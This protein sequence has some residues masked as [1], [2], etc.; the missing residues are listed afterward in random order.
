MTY[1]PYYQH[2]QQPPKQDCD[3]DNYNYNLIDVVNNSPAKFQPINKEIPTTEDMLK[4]GL[5]SKNRCKEDAKDE[6]AGEKINEKK[7]TRKYN[8]LCV[9][10][11]GYQSISDFAKANNM[12]APK[13]RDRRAALIARGMKAEDIT[14]DDIINFVSMRGRYRRP[15]SAAS[16]PQN[17]DNSKLD[18]SAIKQAVQQDGEFKGVEE[19][20]EEK[21]DKITQFENKERAKKPATD[22]YLEKL[23]QKYNENRIGDLEVEVRQL[24]KDFDNLKAAIAQLDK[25]QVG[26]VA[27]N[28]VLE[29]II[30]NIIVKTY[31]K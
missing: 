19:K 20:A 2:R 1:N 28:E 6:D 13:V 27:L 10:F 7:T 15:K 26:G 16:I 3:D 14:A 24:R 21:L 23:G 31:A 18:T 29:Q 30:T 9:P 17:V 12:P 22:D 5:C 25:L 11:C 8:S 4:S